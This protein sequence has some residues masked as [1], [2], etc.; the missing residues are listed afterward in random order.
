[1][2]I[3][4]NGIQTAALCDALIQHS[5][6]GMCP[7]WAKFLFEFAFLALFPSILAPH[8]VSCAIKIGALKSGPGSLVLFIKPYQPQLDSSDSEM[9]SGNVTVLTIC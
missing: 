3:S 2:L 1:L 8:W 6:K 5:S 7:P 4:R 9:P